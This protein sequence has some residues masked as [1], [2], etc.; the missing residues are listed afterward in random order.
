MSCALQLWELSMLIQ[1]QQGPKKIL[2]KFPH[3][4]I[5][6]ILFIYSEYLVLLPK[7]ILVT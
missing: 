4:L 2:G 1:T 6:F 3:T 5:I 7:L